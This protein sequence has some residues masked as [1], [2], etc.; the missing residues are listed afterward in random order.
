[1][2]MGLSTR[3]AVILTLVT[4]F[5]TMALCMCYISIFV[6]PELPLN[7]FPPRG[8]VDQGAAVVDL[9]PSANQPALVVIDVNGS[10]TFPPT[11]TPTATSTS[12]S[13]PTPTFTSTPT[14][15]P[16]PVMVSRNDGPRRTRGR[17]SR[18]TGILRA[19]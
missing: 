4:L 10:P 3:L 13:T 12:T 9:D 16:T 14:L 6:S 19:S 17:G 5:A 15:T 8:A 18:G 1:M 7:P 2:F 11:W